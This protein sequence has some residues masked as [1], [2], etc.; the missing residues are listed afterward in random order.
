MDLKKKWKE[1]NAPGPFENLISMFHFFILF[2]YLNKY[3]SSG[4]VRG[5]TSLEETQAKNRE[6]LERLERE[7]RHSEAEK[8]IEERRHTAAQRAASRRRKETW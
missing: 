3:M 8:Q 2:P 6:A 4:F 7:E 5:T 1:D